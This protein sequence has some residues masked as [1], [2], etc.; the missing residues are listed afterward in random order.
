MSNTEPQVKSCGGG[1]ARSILPLYLVLSSSQIHNKY[2]FIFF[3]FFLFYYVLCF[4]CSM[5]LLPEIKMDWI[6]LEINTSLY[7]I[8]LT[9]LK[10]EKISSRQSAH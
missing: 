9:V 5:G 4:Y 6:G 7:P 10:T 8:T 1:G 3:Y 2:F